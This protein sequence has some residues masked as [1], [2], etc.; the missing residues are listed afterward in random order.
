M[1]DEMSGKGML[2]EKVKKGVL[3]VSPSDKG[4]RLVVMNRDTYDKMTQV[5]VEGDIKTDWKQLEESQK[6]IRNHGTALSRVFGLGRAE[7]RRNKMLQQYEFMGD[8]CTHTKVN[9]QDSQTS[10]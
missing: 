7:G 6:L 10:W 5:H 4:K 8:G 1:K 3:H 9:S 2:E